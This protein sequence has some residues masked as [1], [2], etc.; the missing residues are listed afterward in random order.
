MV[1]RQA[2]IDLKPLELAIGQNSES[3][4]VSHVCDD[5][6][7]VGRQHS[8]SPGRLFRGLSEDY[9]ER[10]WQG[11][12]YYSG[13]AFN[14][15]RHFCRIVKV[16]KT[17]LAQS[18]MICVVGFGHNPMESERFLLYLCLDKILILSQR[19]YL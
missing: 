18:F 9:L 3:N 19:S 10:L 14:T 1:I 12:V 2:G 6:F 13:F 5:S 4:F 8:V 15:I 11:V 7:N 16:K 17:F